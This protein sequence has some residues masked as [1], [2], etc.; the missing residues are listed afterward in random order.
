M[1]RA[2][3]FRLD[4]GFHVHPKIRRLKASLGEAGVLAWIGLLAFAS[5]YKTDGRFGGMT[6]DEI[7]QAGFWTGDGAELIRTL[8]KLRLL[9][10]HGKTLALHD[11]EEHN[12]YAASYMS[13]SE[14]ARKAAK[15]RWGQKPTD[16][17]SN[18]EQSASNAQASG[19]RKHSLSNAPSP[20]PNPNPDPSPISEAEI[21]ACKT[22]SRV[23]VTKEV[24]DWFDNEFLSKYRGPHAQTQRPTALRE[25]AKLTPAGRALALVNLDL[26]NQTPEWRKDDYQFV[27]GPGTFFKN[28]YHLNPPSTTSN[29][30]GKAGIPDAHELLEGLRREAVA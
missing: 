15:T 14:R 19:M 13:R 12:G 23:G 5:Q 28:K 3:D 9:D 6:D 25:A 20:D 26:R 1:A 2:A 17:Q 16:A 21:S 30:T 11:W 29:G 8:V 24:E 4:S 10:R 27:P 7:A 22:R 18:G